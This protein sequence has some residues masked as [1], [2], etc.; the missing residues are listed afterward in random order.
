MVASSL[1]NLRP[2]VCNK[3]TYPSTQGPNSNLTS[4]L[5]IEKVPYPSPSK[6][7]RLTTL[8]PPYVLLQCSLSLQSFELLFQFEAK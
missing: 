7:P 5:A 8:A 6:V 3:L 4:V 2:Q 1:S